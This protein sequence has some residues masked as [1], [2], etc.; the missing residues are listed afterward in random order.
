MKFAVTY[1]QELV[2]MDWRPAWEHSGLLLWR[3]APLGL[4]VMKICPLPSNSKADLKRAFSVLHD[5]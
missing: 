5:I 4:A 2:T 1:D 3:L